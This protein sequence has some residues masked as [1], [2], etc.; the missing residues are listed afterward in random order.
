MLIRVEECLMFSRGVN[1]QYQSAKRAVERVST[2]VVLKSDEMFIS[3]GKDK[4]TKGSRKRGGTRLAAGTRM[5]SSLSR[6]LTG[7]A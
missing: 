2:L 1:R 6:G 5:F 4:V 7:G 3:S